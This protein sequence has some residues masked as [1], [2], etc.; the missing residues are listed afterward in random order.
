MAESFGLA[1][2]TDQ[3]NIVY[4]SNFVVHN[5]QDIGFIHDINKIGKIIE[6]KTLILLADSG[7]VEREGYCSPH[8]RLLPHIEKQMND[9]QGRTF[10]A[11]DSPDFYNIVSEIKNE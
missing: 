8:Y 4:L 11:L 6:E 3:G 1:I 5:D 2:S 10:L 7:G 9:T